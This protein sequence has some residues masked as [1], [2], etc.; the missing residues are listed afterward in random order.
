MRI[1]KLQT[2]DGAEGDSVSVEMRIGSYI[3][4]LDLKKDAPLWRELKRVID[5]LQP[6]KQ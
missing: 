5:A 3:H 2:Y 4:F 1:I 6:K